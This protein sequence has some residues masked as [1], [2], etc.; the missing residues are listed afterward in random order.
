MQSCIFLGEVQ[1]FLGRDL[2][3]LVTLIDKKHNNY[4]EN[5]IY[6]HYMYIK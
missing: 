3:V 1:F 5:T 4:I 6:V 2:T